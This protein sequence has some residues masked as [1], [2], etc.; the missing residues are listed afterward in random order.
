M[1]RPLLNL[2]YAATPIIRRMRRTVAQALEKAGR[3]QDAVVTFG[4][5]LDAVDATN[6]KGVGFSRLFIA[7]RGWPGRLQDSRLIAESAPQVVR[8]AQ[9]I[10]DKPSRSHALVV[11]ARALPN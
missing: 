10:E 3:G 9:S 4:E 5:A 7:L 11:I 1:D 2:D 8:I 6:I